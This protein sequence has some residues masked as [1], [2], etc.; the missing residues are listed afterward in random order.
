MSDRLTIDIAPFTT[1]EI[2]PNLRWFIASQNRPPILQQAYVC[3]ENGKIEW[4]NIE[5]VIQS[6][7]RETE[8]DK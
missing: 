3:K 5:L 6:E 1:W 4:C 2:K 7:Y 8:E